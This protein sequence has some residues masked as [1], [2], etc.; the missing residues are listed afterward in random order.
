LNV[1]PAGKAPVSL[2]VGVGEPVAVTANVPA[3]PT[4]KVVVFA[5]VMAGTWFTVS[6]KFCVALGNTPFAAVNVI[7]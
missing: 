7:G 6:V 1:T 2:N 3:V 4:V 5:L